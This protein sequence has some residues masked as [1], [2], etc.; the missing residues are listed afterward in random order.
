M[1]D[2]VRQAVARAHRRV[3][4]HP[5]AALLAHLLALG[6]YAALTLYL[7]AG[8]LP[9]AASAIPGAGV[10]QED[11]WQNAWNM[12]WVRLALARGQNP[13]HTDMLFSPTG[14][15]LYLHTLNITNSLLTLPVLLTAGP[16][17]AYNVAVALGFVLTG[18]GSFLLAQHVLGHRG[19][20][21][22]IGA[23]VTFSPFHL[24]KLWDGHLSWVTMQWIPCAILCLLRALET[25][26]W[27][28]RVAAG[29]VLAGAALTSWY[30]ALFSAIFAALLL[31][32]RA[33]D[34]WRARRWKGEA[35]TLLSVGPSPGR[36]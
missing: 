25:G 5:S 2:G 1:V 10:A 16:V 29:A 11:G 8:V 4:A 18:Y 3:A 21:V 23:V 7:L 19:V 31:A 17:A 22:A 33:P 20:A 36:C 28:W 24:A 27:R 14:A 34:A 12:W 9:Q 30:Y 6:I 15:S 35:L 13:Y 32:V 26:R